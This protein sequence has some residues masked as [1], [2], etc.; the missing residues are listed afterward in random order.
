MHM[1]STIIKFPDERT[2]QKNIITAYHEVNGTDYIVFKTDKMDNGN[3]VVGVSYKPVNEDR[4][5]K[6]VN[7]ED[8]K[9]AKGILVDDIHGKQDNFIY[10]VI[11]NETLVTEDYI[12]D[13]ALR[14]ANKG[15]L[16]AHYQEFLNKQQSVTEEPTVEAPQE[17]VAPVVAPNPEPTP[18]V[19]EAPVTPEV[20]PVAPET[21]A[22]SIEPIAPTPI[23]ENNSNITPFPGLENITPVGTEEPVVA[24]VDIAPV[25]PEIQVAPSTPEVITP[26]EQ[27][28]SETKSIVTE[29]YVSKANGLIEEFKAV[30]DKFAKNMEELANEMGRELEEAHHI[31]ELSRQTFDN[32]QQI[33]N[34]TN[35]NELTRDL[36]KVA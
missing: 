21:V 14:D 35:N 26:V 12:H 29:S 32:A 25:Q 8:W 6:I 5:Q 15:A 34:N 31:N 18:V 24:P 17:E 36:S 10:K 19:A 3:E 2:E 7:M 20:T 4:Y 13:L 23:I 27:P 9:K 28:V 11:D 16:E 1:A 30:A 22:P 33:V